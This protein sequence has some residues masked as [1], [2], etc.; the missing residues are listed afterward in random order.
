MGEGSLSCDDNLV[1]EL[2]EDIRFLSYLE[3]SLDLT[4]YLL[5]KITDIF[6]NK[7]LQDIIYKGK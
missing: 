7:I 1:R 5:S 2:Q 3:E 4:S 6:L